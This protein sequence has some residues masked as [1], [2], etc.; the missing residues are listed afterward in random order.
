MTTA[1]R[2]LSEST[3]S[4]HSDWRLRIPEPQRRAIRRWFWS[5]AAV[6][7]AVLIVGGITR[8][9]HSG[10]SI[11]N[12][13]PIMGV[14]PPLNDAQWQET[15]DAYRQFP[16]YQQ[17]RQGMTLGEFKFIFFWEYLHRLLARA[18]GM[19]FLLPFL[20]FLI[21]GY[22]NGPLITRALLLFG[23]GALQGLVGWLMVASGLV[24]RPSVSHYRL[25]AHLSLAFL[26]FG[27]AL[28]LARDLAAPRS[29]TEVSDATRRMLRRGLAAIGVLLGLQIVWG[30][31]VAGLKA[32]YYYNTFP[33]M[34]GQWI[35]PGLLMLEPASMN[36][37][38]NPVA[39]Q[40]IHRV[41]GTV[42]LLAGAAF[43][44]SVRRSDADAASRTF[45]TALLALLATQYLLGILTLLFIVPVSLGVA[46][47]TMALVLFGVWVAWVHHA[48]ELGITAAP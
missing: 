17:R 26:I 36:V 33:L 39:V 42:L 14:V 1:A 11:V 15:F 9:T 31:F 23:L 38:D 41:L 6:T 27:G 24:D 3:P 8:L 7:L 4:S 45:N 2:P 25:A 35:P 37:L 43:W 30:A 28:W 40:W 12:W 20:Y 5:I 47:Q 34:A 10:L 16:E 13:D 48:R 21:R 18:I 19:V 22:L 29:R 46:H 32:G 44:W